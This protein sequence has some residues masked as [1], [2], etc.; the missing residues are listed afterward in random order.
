MTLHV[1]NFMRSI[2]AE[3][4]P[5]LQHAA[6]SAIDAG[7]T[8]IQIHMSSDGG[9]ND[10]GF[11]AYHFLRSLPI[12][13]NMH[14][15]G[16]VESMAVILF[17]AGANRLIVPHGKVKIH[18]MLWNFPAGTVDHDRL[19]EYVASLDFDAKRYAEIFDERTQGSSKVVDV[20][21]H[22]AGQ[23]RLM[24]SAAAVSSGIAT[25]IADATIPA[26]AIRW[27]V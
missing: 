9:N 15:I 18:P 26:T 5:V 10:Q 4:L 11:A 23:A 13:V 12:P 17:L 14:C 16:N 21:A 24:D 2:N 20:R 6:L 25:G 22:L 3:T 1:I 19:V 27:W 8:E 7:A